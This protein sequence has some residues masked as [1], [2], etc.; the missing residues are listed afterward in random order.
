MVNSESQKLIVALTGLPRVR[1]VDAIRIKDKFIEQLT[2]DHETLGKLEIHRLKAPDAL[3]LYDFYLKGLSEEARNLFP[4]YPLF[5]PPVSSTE[6]LRGRIRDWGKEH[7][8]TFLKLVKDDEIIGVCLLKRWSTGR[9]TSGLAVH[10]KF[11]N[12][13][14]GVL[15]QTVVNEQAVLLGLKGVYATVAPDNAASLKTH[16]RCGFK[17]TG[18][19]VAHYSYKNGIKEFERNDVELSLE[20]RN[21]SD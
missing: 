6:E 16:E 14:L 3:K 13:G 9:P 1:S 7:D 5:S 4:P 10:E 20:L 12:S 15:L 11:R 21:Q 18:K 8:W 2:F 17:R 19:T